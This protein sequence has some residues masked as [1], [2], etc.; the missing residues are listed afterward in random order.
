MSK[1][2]HKD[3]DEVSL[4]EFINTLMT[5][6]EISDQEL[7]DEL[8]YSSPNIIKMFRE[9]KVR[10]PLAQLPKLARAVSANPDWVMEQAVREY[11]PDSVRV[12]IGTHLRGLTENQLAI[13][14][15]IDEVSDSSDPAPTDGGLWTKIAAAVNSD[16]E[17]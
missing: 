12:L 17:T 4:A 11:F 1:S 5:D 10:L 8:G 16:Q 13:L 6:L 7:A 3:G 15:L 2:V 9:G 14:A